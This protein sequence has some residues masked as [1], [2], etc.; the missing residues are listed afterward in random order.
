VNGVSYRV[1]GILKAKGD[2]GWFNPD[3]QIIVPYTTAMKQV[4]GMNY[5]EEVDL[6]A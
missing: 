5:L 4:L 1:V 6:S 3:D 2:Q